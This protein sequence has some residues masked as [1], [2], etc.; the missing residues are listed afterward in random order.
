M[1]FISKKKIIYIFLIIGFLIISSYSSIAI[2]QKNNYFIETTLETKPADLDWWPMYRHDSQNIGY[3]TNIPPVTNDLLWTYQTDDGISSSPVVMH[4]KVY[5]GSWDY[6]LYCFDME[7][8]SVIWEYQTNGR[9][10]SSPAIKNNRVY[11]GSRDSYIYCLD[12]V[13]G[14]LIWS[15]KTGYYIE[16][17]PVI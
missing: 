3:S 14:S 10:T 13:D 17:S 5:V 2:N 9:I 4:G 12:A 8:G 7:T 16:S 11:F 6:S 15:Y 1:K